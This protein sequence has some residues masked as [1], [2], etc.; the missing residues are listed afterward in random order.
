MNTTDKDPCPPGA[1]PDMAFLWGPG[2]WPSLSMLAVLRT[3]REW[4]TAAI[5]SLRC[6]LWTKQPLSKKREQ[7]V[8]PRD[9]RTKE[10]QGVSGLKLPKEDKIWR[11]SWAR[12]KSDNSSLWA[13]LKERGSWQ[14]KER[15]SEWS[16]FLDVQGGP[17]GELRDRASECW[18]ASHQRIRSS[19]G[20]GRRPT[21]QEWE[22]HPGIQIWGWLVGLGHSVGSLW[23]GWGCG[24]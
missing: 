11:S 20:F 1:F 17:D 13:I 18:I 4:L 21:E 12:V 14:K 2:L 10:R 9:S 23:H 24:M 5:S 15:R 19:W 6:A 16:K 3:K 22:D 7:G 8:K